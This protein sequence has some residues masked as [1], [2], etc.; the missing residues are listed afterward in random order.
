MREKKS[1]RTIVTVQ[2]PEDYPGYEAYA[3]M[4]MVSGS[5]RTSDLSSDLPVT[6]LSGLSE[7]LKNGDRYLT[8]RE[9]NPSR[10]FDWGD[11]TIL[12][13]GGVS[14]GRAYLFNLPRFL[15]DSEMRELMCAAVVLTKTG[16]DAQDFGLSRAELIKMLSIS[17]YSIYSNKPGWYQWDKIN[18]DG[19][20]RAYNSL[21]KICG[22]KFR[23]RAEFFPSMIWSAY[24]FLVA[25]KGEVL[26]DD[27]YKACSGEEIKNALRRR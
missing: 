16:E 15:S 14:T 21:K 6:N 23:N 2:R 10:V 4:A 17:G 7:E 1:R 3:Q 8:Y 18:Q 11:T 27:G 12:F 13:V 20:T 5:L 25:T 26:D 22:E 9:V 24:A 19:M